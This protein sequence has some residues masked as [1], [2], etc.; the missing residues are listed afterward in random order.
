MD[1]IV[2]NI[3]PQILFAPLVG[4]LLIAFAGPRLPR[5]VSAV[6]GCTSIFAA[7]ALTVGLAFHVWGL[8]VA[9]QRIDISLGTWALVGS[10]HIGFGL[11]IDP[12]AL[13]WMLVITGVGFL[14][15]LYS[16]GYMGHDANYRTFFAHMNLFVF[17]MLLLV[18]ADGFLW[19][20]VGWGG[21]GLASYLLIGFY[22]DRR[23][24]VLAARKALIMNVIGDVGIMIA[25]FLMFAHIGDQ[26]FAVVFAR[27]GAFGTSALDWIGIW[28]LVGA[29][30]KSAQLPLHT[31]LPDAMEGPT[32]VSALIHAATMV[33]AG[34]Y[35]VARC[36]PIY[37]HAPAAA[38]AV[39]VV[40]AASALFAATIGCVQYDIKRVLAYSTMS[41][42]GYMFLGVGVGAYTAGAFH[43]LTHAFFKALLFMA[44]GIVIHNLGGEQD[45]RKMGGLAKKMPFAYWTFLAGTLAIAGVPPF[46]GFF[47]KDSILDQAADLGHPWLFAI[48][49]LAAALTAFYMF[50]LF[51]STFGGEYRGSV[52]PHVERVPTMDIPVGILAVLATIGGFLVLPGH[53]TFSALLSGAF[54]DAIRPLSLEHFNWALVFGTLMVVAAG[55]VTA[56][57]MYVISPQVRADVS[58]RLSGLRALLLDAYHVDAIYHALFEVPAYAIARACGVVFERVVIAGVPWALAAATNALGGL[59]R[60]WETGYLRRYGL[61]IAIGATL[62]LY[63]VLLGIHGDAAGIH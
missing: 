29:V 1:A 32:P 6:I 19:L 11:W 24:A 14:I 27:T 57:A 22:Y 62:L 36:H 46:S 37:D 15:H 10:A 61:T 56:Y 5:S 41:Q 20:L 9:A 13:T 53:D 34:V 40:G 31:W 33:T 43:F 60:G 55:I 51:F 38:E 39:A 48:G 8:P 16:V 52:E 21:V 30:A 59:S 50:R 2:A 17:S 42:I 45:I 63:F 3:A 26:S 18:M 23:S 25:I 7:F 47:S 28:L 44:A 54:T 49:V 4:C 12:L 58:L 35:L